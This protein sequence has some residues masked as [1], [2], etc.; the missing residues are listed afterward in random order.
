MIWGNQKRNKIKAAP[1]KKAMC[2]LCKG[3]LIPKCG[4]IMIWH[5]AHKSNKDCDDWYEPESVW[6]KDWKD[7]FPKECQEVTIGKHRADI[8]IGELIVELQNTPLSADKI[9]ERENFYGNMVWI[10]NGR[11]LGNGLNLKKKKIQINKQSQLNGNPMEK[12]GRMKEITTFRWKHPPK[13]WWVANKPIFIDFSDIQEE[14]GRWIKPNDYMG[15]EG[16]YK[17]ERDYMKRDILEIKKIY[18]KIPCAG[19]GILIKKKGLLNGFK[20]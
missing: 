4:K 15:Y 9:Q 3:E 8:K 16:Y 13:S 6:H 11:A 19:W 7:N 1:N 14:S 18:K 20:I 17:H 2:P 5:W 10:L 12:T